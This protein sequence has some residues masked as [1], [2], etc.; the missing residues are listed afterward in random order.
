M[1]W[2]NSESSLDHRITTLHYRQSRNRAS[3]TKK[4]GCSIVSCQIEQAW[5]GQPVFLPFCHSRCARCQCTIFCPGR[6]Q[7][8]CSNVPLPPCSLKELLTS[9]LTLAAPAP[10]VRAAA[11]NCPFLIALCELSFRQKIVASMQ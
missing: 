6:T 10:A 3:A 5:M 9:S 4:K 2:V 7:V 1:W 11:A 8:C